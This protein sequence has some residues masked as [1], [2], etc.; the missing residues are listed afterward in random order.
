MLELTPELRTDG[1]KP[2]YTQL[3]EYIKT[4]ILE[5][6]IKSG[7]K[8][9]SIRT[10]SKHL[11]ISRN[12]VVTAYE[13][14]LSEGYVSSQWRSGIY[15]EEIHHHIIRHIEVPDSFNDKINPQKN[16]VKYSFDLRNAQIDLDSFPYAL[17]RKVLNQCVHSDMSELLNYGEHQGE[18]E[19]REQISRYLF[20][21]RGVKCRPEQILIGAGT[22]QSLS[23]LSIILREVGDS[24]AFEEPGY[25]GARKVFIDNNFN[26]VPIPVDSDGIDIA[27]LDESPSKIAY[28]TPSHQFPCGM[29]MP[30]SKR[31]MLLKWAQRKGGFIIEDDY[32]GEFRYQSKPIPALQGL[33]TSGSVIYLGTFSKSLIPSIRIS[34]MVLPEKLLYIYKAR[35][36]IYEQPVSRLNQKALQLFMEQGF[37]NRHIKRMRNIYKKKHDILIDS[38]TAVLGSRVEIIGKDAGLHVLINVNNGMDE[39][40]LIIR[41]AESGVGVS[42][43]SQYWYNQDCKYPTRIFIGFGGIRQEDIPVSILRL[44]RSWL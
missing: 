35:Y 10:L 8:L 38:I 15:V 3:Y 9:P 14:L 29:V 43:T 16:T 6:D 13:Q 20:L 17:W 31:L 33:D 26:I 18:L 37:W 28:I 24:V 34:Y 44:K 11:N 41:A 30:V 27:S 2:L 21:S 42:P 23:M 32:D 1:N 39:K 5:E 22:Q 40:E 25:N 12:T 4:S 7:E 36:S 19:L